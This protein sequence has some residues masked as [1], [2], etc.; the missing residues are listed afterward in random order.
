MNRRVWMRFTAVTG[1]LGATGW[2][3]GERL[4]SDEPLWVKQLVGAARPDRQ[5]LELGRLYLERIGNV[6]PLPSA[7]ID[8]DDA[9]AWLFAEIS[10]DVDADR[11]VFVAGWIVTETE[12]NVLTWLYLRSRGAGPMHPEA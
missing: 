11:T 9:A 2:L 7:L 4:W 3:I 10:K 12:A 6:A 8:G 1:A 5:S